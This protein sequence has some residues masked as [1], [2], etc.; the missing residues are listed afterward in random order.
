M[1]PPPR[2]SGPERNAPETLTAARMRYATITRTSNGER[3]A[4]TVARSHLLEAVASTVSNVGDGA[5]R[6][7]GNQ[8]L[9]C[10]CHGGLLAVAVPSGIE[11]L[12]LVYVL[13]FLLGSTETLSAGASFALV[14]ALVDEASLERAN[15][16]VGAENSINRFD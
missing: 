4:K 5:R 1:R 16:P 7:G 10:R 3:E 13:V 12:W 2:S 11:S 9:L 14:P 8:Y 6:D 15:G